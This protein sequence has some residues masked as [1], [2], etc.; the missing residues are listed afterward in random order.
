MR[1]PVHVYAHTVLLFFS[2]ILL[3]VYPTAIGSEPQD[4]TLESSGHWE[5]TM[6]GHSAA[7]LVPVVAS[8]RIGTEVFPKSQ[9]TFYGTMRI[10]FIV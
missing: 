4:P 6:S 9:I 8:N 7:N 3:L 10:N 5:R 2:S 1:R